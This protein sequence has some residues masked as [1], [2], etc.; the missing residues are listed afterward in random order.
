MN[1]SP[2]SW[3]NECTHI[4]MNEWRKLWP[5]YSMSSFSQ[6][7]CIHYPILSSGYPGE[8]YWNPCYTDGTTESQSKDHLT[9]A[10]HRACPRIPARVPYAGCWPGLRSPKRRA[11]PPKPG[12]L[13]HPWSPSSP[14]EVTQKAGTTGKPPEKRSSHLLAREHLWLSKQSS[15]FSPS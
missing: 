14:P 11:L 8:Q 9:Q 1:T 13:Q 7:L 15:M 3:L 10:N 5:T 2:L 6:H 4:S 12:N